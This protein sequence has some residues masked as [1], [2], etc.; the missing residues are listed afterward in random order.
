MDTMAFTATP[1]LHASPSSSNPI[2]ALDSLISNWDTRR[3][4]ANSIAR[5]GMRILEVIALAAAMFIV[6]GLIH[7]GVQCID[8]I[9]EVLGRRARSPYAPSIPIISFAIA[10]VLLVAWHIWLGRLSYSAIMEQGAGQTKQK[11]AQTTEKTSEKRVSWGRI[12][13]R[14][15]IPLVLLSLAMNFSSQLI[16]RLA[17]PNPWITPNVNDAVEVQREID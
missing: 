15:V 3:H 16:Q 6:P 10:G 17:N 14:I 7:Y 13:G 4:N 5:L 12:L 2:N 9:Y 8:E 1:S 11:G